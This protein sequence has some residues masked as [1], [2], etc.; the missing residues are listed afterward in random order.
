[1]VINKKVK[2]AVHLITKTFNFDAL[3]FDI[4]IF[5]GLKSIYLFAFPYTSYCVP[6][7]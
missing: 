5:E 3:I 2:V 6:Y 4:K 7:H 1:M